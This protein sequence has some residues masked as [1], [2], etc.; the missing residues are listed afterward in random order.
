QLLR[1]LCKEAQI[2]PAELLEHPVVRK[3]I[4]P[5]LWISILGAIEQNTQKND[6]SLLTQG[7][8]TPWITVRYAAAMALAQSSHDPLL[9]E[10]RALL[11][12]H[13]GDHEA[14]PV[15][16]A[17]AYALIRSNDENGHE[18]LIRLLNES[19]PLE[20]HK[21]ALFMLATEPPIHF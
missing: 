16:L 7:L 3:P 9:A 5:V 18:V 6:E 15:R 10:T 13:L 14:F 11:N 21:A 8:T 2:E 17:A 12:D 20:V 4:G 19:V 1:H